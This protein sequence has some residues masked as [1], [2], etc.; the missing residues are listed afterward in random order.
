MYAAAAQAGARGLLSPEDIQDVRRIS[1]PG[2]PRKVT[3]VKGALSL[4]ELYRAT[5]VDYTSRLAA[6]PAPQ[7]RVLSL[8]AGHDASVGYALIVADSTGA[9]LGR[10]AV[11][12]EG[13]GLGGTNQSRSPGGARGRIAEKDAEGQ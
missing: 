9:F 4:V 11:L 12:A 3:S 5:A 2:S 6:A 8:G 7:E 10:S 1:K 13:E